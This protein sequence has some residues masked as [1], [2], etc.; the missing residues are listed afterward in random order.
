LTKSA[1]AWNRISSTFS[2]DSAKRDFRQK[3]RFES[4]SG[5][6]T[7]RQNGKSAGPPTKKRP[8]PRRCVSGEIADTASQA[9]KF[10]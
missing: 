2:V 9:T 7:G 4:S 6:R 1:K 10:G 8:N 5:G 3:C